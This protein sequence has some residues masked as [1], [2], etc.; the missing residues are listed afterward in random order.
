MHDYKYDLD[1]WLAASYNYYITFE[2]TGMSDCEFDMLS[3][4]LL[5]HWDTFD[6]CMKEK[7]GKD[8]MQCGSGF[9]LK[10]SDY[11]EKIRSESQPV[12]R[13]I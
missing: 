6:H 10:A 2:D 12:E 7:V 4:K 13:S 3:K 8:A 1:R 9:H 11:P 5:D